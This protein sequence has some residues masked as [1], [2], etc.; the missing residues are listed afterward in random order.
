MEGANS[1]DKGSYENILHFKS[2][3]KEKKAGYRDF[4]QRT[5]VSGEVRKRTIRNFPLYYL[6]F[7]DIDRDFFELESFKKKIR[8]RMGREDISFGGTK[9]AYMHFRNEGKS[10]LFTLCPLLFGEGNL[11]KIFYLV[12]Q[13]TIEGKNKFHVENYLRNEKGEKKT[14][15]NI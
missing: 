4:L 12:R 11:E 5:K 8:E 15:E 1:L 7:P 9:Y 6:D 13:R 2:A 3:L 14:L 10:E